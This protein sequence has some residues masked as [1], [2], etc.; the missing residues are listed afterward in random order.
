MRHR[1][2]TAALLA[3]A[4]SAGV[5]QVAK[6]QTSIERFERQL[7]QIQRDTRMRIN[8]DVPVD[9]RTLLDYGG[10]FTFSFFAIDD[11]E[12]N[13][14]I[15]RQYDLVGYARINIDNVHE[16]HLRARTS[17]RDFGN[18]D[19]F[20][21]Q[22]DEMLWP[23]VEQAYYRFDLARYLAAYK[24][25]TIQN[26]L[27][28]TLGRQ[29]IYW[30]NGMV[31]AEYLD[32][33]L[34]EVTLGSISL[35]LLGGQTIHD[36]IDIDA[37]RPEFDEKTQRLFYGGMAT[38]Q[39]GKHRPF[40]YG[41]VQ[42]DRNDDEVLVIGQSRTRFD[43]NSW[44]LGVGANGSFTD[45]LVYGVEFAYEGGNTLSNSFDRDTLAAIP[46]ERD[47]IQSGALDVKLDYLFTDPRRSRLSFEVIA[48]TGDPDRAHTT[49]TLGGN[50]PGTQDHA[51][52]SW[53]L[54]NT[55]LAFAPNVSNIISGRIGGSIFPFPEANRFRRMQVGAD[56]LGYFKYREDSPIDEVTTDD[57]FLGWEP[58][59]YLNWQ[60][61]SDV[62]FALRYGVFFPGEAIVE[63]QHPRNFFFMG[64]TFA[65]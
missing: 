23:T 42:R 63:D 30:A 12:Q 18:N 60:I 13:T 7:Q 26:N 62:T 24:N 36:T 51:F 5:A 10:Y 40:V 17:F 4:A 58:D 46:Q 33:G 32:G 44:Y 2:L 21:G 57:R 8:P 9:Q 28:V 53:G 55:G 49:N 35:Q 52:N 31:L 20:D 41:L 15:L 6:A 38:V 29:F 25:Q 19:S 22:G 59:V 39:V 1:L 61:S 48:A 14:H 37:T 3:V 54:L 16:F 56:L 64:V 50:A 43:Y 34:A 65:F 27:T 47:D 45:Q 11:I